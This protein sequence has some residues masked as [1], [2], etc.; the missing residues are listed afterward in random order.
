MN[1][2]HIN[3]NYL[4]SRLHENLMD[5]IETE[6][7]H[8]T[9]FM[10]IKSE[11]K[12]E[13]LYESKH[14]IFYPVTFTDRDKYIFTWKQKK[15]YK[16]LKTSVTLE[17]FDL[18]HA[19]TLFTDGNVAYNIKKDFDIPYI[20]TVR[21]Y[22]DIHNFFKK[23]VNLRNKGK[24]I[25]ADASKIIFLSETN[26]KDLLKDYIKDDLLKENIM[27][28]SIILPNGIDNFW[29][30]NSGFP[31]SLDDTTPI[32]CLYAGKI[33]KDK[34]VHGLIESVRIFN[35]K[36]TSKAT[37]FIVGEDYE[38]NYAR[39]LKENAPDFVT[40]STKVT[41]ET[42]IDFYR[43]NDIFLMPSFH[44]TFGLVYPEAMSQ[45]LP[46]V[47][48]KNQGFDGKFSDGEIGYAVNPNDPNDIADK[49]IEIVNNYNTISKNALSG[50]K[51]FDWKHISK[52][53]IEIYKGISD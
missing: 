11:K 34:N 2:L 53:Y 7:I 21:G 4:T 26:R 45:G 19:H 50:F 12:S 29:F 49:I 39:D 17:G 30:E 52:K 48:A 13:F 15:I 40:F 51:K 20:V 1:V 36:S 38:P 31:K 6:E 47:F 22:T 23:R 46:V 9:V 27:E 3:S 37:L 28:K 35:Q 10:P 5:Q 44:E 43:N 32:K 16:K 25:L 33:M 41:R 8:N 14:K 18:T 42:L 24:K